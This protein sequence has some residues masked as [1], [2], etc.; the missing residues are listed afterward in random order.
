MTHKIFAPCAVWVF[1]YSCRQRQLPPMNQRVLV[2]ALIFKRLHGNLLTPTSQPTSQSASPDHEIRPERDPAPDRHR[3]R[4]RVSSPDKR[5]GSERSAQKG[6]EA[7][8]VGAGAAG[9]CTATWVIVKCLTLQTNE[10]R[11]K[12]ATAAVA[13]AV[14][15]A[16]ALGCAD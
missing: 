9:S 1:I 10:I 2:C 12:C 16:V 14:A 13:V 11:L 5:Q 4:D 15:V 8:A 6:A 7:G 3:H